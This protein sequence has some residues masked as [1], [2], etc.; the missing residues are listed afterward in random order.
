MS[1]GDWLRNLG[2]QQYESAFIENGIDIDVLPELTESDLEKLGVL[3]GDRKRFIRAIKTLA[4]SSPTAVGAGPGDSQA[5]YHTPIR[6]AERRHLTV[7]ICDLV[8][9]TALSARLDP[10][11]MRAV[12]D[13]YHATCARI[14]LFYDGFL[15][16]F[17]GDGILAIFGYPRAHEDDAD[18]TVRAGIDIAAAVARLKTPAAT[19]LSVRIG[20]ATGLVLVRSLGGE[21]AL[22]DHSVV[23]DAPNIAARLQALVAPGTVVVAAST[24]RLL[25][26]RFRLRELGRHEIKGIAEPVAAFAVEGVAAAESRFEAGHPAGLANLIDREKE[27]G[28]LLERQGLA[29]KGEGQIVLISGEAGIGKSRLV[30][31]LAERIENEPHT[32]LRYQ[33]SPHY[34][35][36]A[37]HP[38]IAQLERAAGLK[39]DDTPEQRLDKLE[40]L[41]ARSAA[42]G[43]DTAPLLAALMS[44]PFDDRF[45]RLALTPAQQRR[46]TLAALLDQFENLARQRPILLVF[47]DAHWA[48]ATSLE[49]LDLA[50]ERIRRLPVLALFTLRPDFEPPWEGL[51]NVGTLT[52]GRLDPGQVEDIVMQMT[53]GDALP[54]EVM[55]EIVAKT[56]GNPLFV[57]ELTKAVLESDILIREANRYRLSGPL[58]P[59]AIPATLQDSLMARLD[60]LH[61]VKDVAQ[62]GAAM[63]REFSYALIR[64]LVAR[65]ETALGFALVKLEEAGLLFRRG[66]PP[67][68]VY[69]FKHALVRDAAYESLLKSRRQLLHG[70][71]ARAIETQSPEIAVSQPEIVAHHFT[72]AG[73]AEA[74]V[75]YWLKA[76]NLALSR[77]ANTAVNHLNEGLKQ[78][79]RIGDSAIRNKWELLLQTSLG[80][81][82]QAAKGWSIESVKHAYTRALELCKESGLDEHTLPAVFGLW[83]WNFVHPSL[84]EAQALAEYLLRTAENVRNPV[85]KVLAHEALGFTLFAQGK[86]TASHAE[87]QRSI[88][89]CEDSAAVTYL[90][91][92]AQDPQVH[93]RLY[94]GMVLWFLG[95]P[96]QALRTCAEARRYA[97]ASQYPFS[98]AMARTISLRV[99]QLRGEAADVAAQVDAAV[100]LCEE[101]EFVHYL[102]MALILRGWAN[103]QQGHFEKGIADIQLGLEK[104]RATGALL[105]DSY[106]LALLADACLANQHY[107][108]ALEFL[109]QA[110]SRLNHEHCERFYAAEIYR[111]LGETH[112]RLHHD[113]GQAE[114]WFHKGL[115][116]TREQKAKSLELKLCLAMCDLGERR[117]DTAECRSHLD[118]VYRS[119][120]EG[121]E[122]ADLVRAKARLS[123][124]SS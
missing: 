10:E 111:L 83:T 105:Y 26:D 13:A 44:I 56:D 19:P 116:V 50:V 21:G 20:I 15:A 8:D 97:D 57:E 65:D 25:G 87:L 14:T 59:L 91:L 11:D 29:W 88:N 24:R 37:L 122:T 34:S 1:V 106:T 74:A 82:L 27:L 4:D 30:A 117:H 72:E 63:G 7:M 94:D 36:S 95:Y 48:D 112:L 96:D 53:Q 109:E 35:N 124:P 54:S 51:P 49:L 120:T 71:I 67:D 79:H 66:E 40:A 77:S 108:E 46:R 18:R 39:A 31:A 9:S 84:N 69:T 80:N 115:Q 60:R 81:A 3:L 73:F 41:L 70:Q 99:H 52:L 38:I 12:M 75:G 6:A 64:E 89:L 68:A 113:L 86:F 101:H 78:V 47:E 28:F 62:V 23:G 43:D 102:A 61:P 92:S 123:T 2:L 76:G 104:Q 5:P 17:R 103:A 93:V 110:Q 121:F 85:Y 42:A 55:K 58:P 100:A 118:A 107:R 119:F 114:R 90:D 32:V 22:R 33:C 98:E 45:P 16:D